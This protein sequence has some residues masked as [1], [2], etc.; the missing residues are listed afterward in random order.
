M[1]GSIQTWWQSCRRM[2][3]D[4]QLHHQAGPS[5]ILIIADLPGWPPQH[6]CLC[7]DS[8][9]QTWPRQLELPV[10]LLDHRTQK[11][12]V[13]QS[14][15]DQCSA[16]QSQR[17]LQKFLYCLSTFFH[18]YSCLPGLVLQCLRLF[19]SSHQCCCFLNQNGVDITLEKVR[20][21][22]GVATSWTSI[23]GALAT[24]DSVIGLIHVDLEGL[25]R[26]RSDI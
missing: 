2:Y 13:L 26:H 9:L 11:G 15:W 3:W 8:F 6:G 14:K 17:G 19:C 24:V 7:C 1:N 4:V 22:V 18:G 5:G 21:S 10:L 20:E 16:Q 25:Q 12:I 23:G